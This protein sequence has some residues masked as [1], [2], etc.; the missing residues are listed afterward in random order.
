[1]TMTG[2]AF[3]LYLRRFFANTPWPSRLAGT[4]R[5]ARSLPGSR[6][7]PYRSVPMTTARCGPASRGAFERFID[8][9]MKGPIFDTAKLF[10]HASR[11][12]SRVESDGAFTQELPPPAILAPHP[13][14]RCRSVFSATPGTTGADFIDYIIAD[15]IVVARKQEER[16]FYS[17]K[18]VHLPDCCQAERPAQ[19]GGEETDPQRGRGTA[20]ARLRVLL[21][22]TRAVK[23]TPDVF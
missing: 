12:T 2:F 6:P 5:T 3:A 19:G 17:E 20:G 11:S 14:H 21:P 1:M 9:D 23:M 4:G 18:V 7:S 13:R 10:A 8:V 15:R 16:A 22:S